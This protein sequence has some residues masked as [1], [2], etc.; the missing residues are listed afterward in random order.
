MS[1]YT[2]KPFSIILGAEADF[3][4]I[5]VASDNPENPWS[6]KLSSYKFAGIEL[7][8]GENRIE[9]S[10]AIGGFGF[11][12]HNYVQLAHKLYSA[13]KEV[14]CHTTTG[15][16]CHTELSCQE[17]LPSVADLMFKIELVNKEW[18]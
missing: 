11:P 2:N 18:F 8:S 12:E 1:D 9:I 3:S 4:I 17:L 14:L 15:T 16:S 5:T 6:L 13:N 10:L 7:F